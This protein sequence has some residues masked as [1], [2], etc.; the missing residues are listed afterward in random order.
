[1]PERHFPNSAGTPREKMAGFF[2]KIGTWPA[3]AVLIFAAAALGFGQADSPRSPQ[4][5]RVELIREDLLPKPSATPL[6]TPTGSSE[7]LETVAT[8]IIYANSPFPIIA[9]TPIPGRSGVLIEDIN[10][11]VI[12]ESSSDAAFNPASNV[13]LATA[14]AVLVTFGPNFRFIT[15]VWTDGTLDSETGVLDGNLY[16]SGRDPVFAYEH[17]ILLAD[18]LNRMGIRSIT[19][20]LIVTENFVINRTSSASRSAKSMLA[21]FDSEKRSSAAKRAWSDF[22]FYSGKPGRFAESPGLVFS[23]EAAI[24]PIPP[25]TRLLFAHESAAMREIVKAMLSFSSNFLAARLGEML[26]GPLAVARIVHQYT[27]AEPAEFYM[28]TSSGLGINRVTP[29]AM[30][31]L[32]RALRADLARFDMR[33]ADIL[34][35]AGMDE[36]TLENRFD[37]DFSRGSVVGKTG[38]LSHTDGGVSTLAGEMNTRSGK[39]LFVIF[40]QRG[41]VSRFRAFQN[42]Y[43]SLIQ[44]QLGGAA[45]LDYSPISIEARL[46]TNRI[47]YPESRVLGN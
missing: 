41:R 47:S 9:E 18:E 20:N 22:R 28:Q 14:Y 10:G 39:V 40:N 8:P 5:R 27:G 35:V 23:G 3:A 21:Y 12:V 29:R 19:G 36:G 15:N 34:P 30:M 4:T 13:K 25:G 37:T 31:K 1:M 11:N 2:E 43:I 24:G 44:G 16:V 42:S 26:G 6:V 46:A 45:Q 38:T 17:A 33:L 32:L 7:P